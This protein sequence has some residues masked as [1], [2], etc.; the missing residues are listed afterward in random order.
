MAFD[1]LRG[2]R[3][4]MCDAAAPPS[5]IVTMAAPASSKRP[6][7]RA[8]ATFPEPMHASVM[9][10]YEYSRMPWEWV[11]RAGELAWPETTARCIARKVG[12]DHGVRAMA[13]F[14]LAA[15]RWDDQ[16]ETQTDDVMARLLEGLACLDG[17]TPL[18]REVLHELADYYAPLPLTAPLEQ[19][20]GGYPLA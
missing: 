20:A 3:K 1:M 5:Q 10:L 11:K 13:I 18:S 6:V 19:R 17:V 9:V 12:G 2:E 15:S 4:I 14:A 8:L 7:S 16:R